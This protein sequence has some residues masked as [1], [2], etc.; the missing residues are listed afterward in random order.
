MDFAG[1]LGKRGLFVAVAGVTAVGLSGCF[2]FEQR[3]ALHRDG[4]GTYAQQVAADGM[5]GRAID[6]KHGDIDFDDDDDAGGVRVLRVAHRDG[7]T[8]QIS[9][10]RFHDFSDLKLG[11]ETLGLHVKG[12]T[13]DGETEVNFR[14]EFQINHA[15]HRHDDDAKGFGRDVL[16]TMF[17]GHTYKFAVWLPGRIEHIAPVRVAGREVHPTVWADATGHT[18][19]WKMDLSDAFLADTVAFD[20]DFAAKGEFHDTKSR[21]GEHHV[22]HRHHHDDGD[23]DDDDDGD[24]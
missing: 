21:P 3:V 10:R 23:D 6:R 2:D 17:D 16:E 15:R 13:A 11:D 22:H 4:S 1:F 9:E 8:L 5:V 20:V 24:I 18:V 19:M 12:K 7:K 14:R